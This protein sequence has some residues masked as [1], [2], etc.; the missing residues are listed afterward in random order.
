MHPHP[1]PLTSAGF[2]PSSFVK[3]LLLKREEEEIQD[4]IQ[5]KTHDGYLG[6]RGESLSTTALG[7]F[8]SALGHTISWPQNYTCT[9]LFFF[10]QEKPL[11]LQAVM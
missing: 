5:T 8:Q 2:F 9:Q 1:G 3:Q 4:S 6:I 11:E 7:T 10:K